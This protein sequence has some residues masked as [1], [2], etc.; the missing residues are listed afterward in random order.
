MH[1]LSIGTDRRVFEEGN[2][3]RERQASYAKTLGSLDVLIFSLGKRPEEC[4][5][6]LRLVPTNSSSR[7]LYGLDAYR[8]AKQLERPDVVTAQD[9]FE[10]GLI[11]LL[12]AR[13]FGVPLHVQVHTDF[14]SRQFARHS[15]LNR[16]RKMLASFVLSRAARIRVILERTKDELRA[17]GVSAPITVLPIFVDTARFSSL[18]RV[19]HPRFKIALLSIGRLEPEKRVELAVRALKESRDVGH[20]AGLTIVGSGSQEASLRS[21]AHSLGLEQYVEFVGWR[22]D[23]APY[24]ASADALLVPSVYE[25]YGIVTIEALAAGVPVIAT[26]V[27][28]A[29]EAGAIVAREGAFADTVIDWIAHGPRQGALHEYPYTSFEDYVERYCTDIVACKEV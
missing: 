20:D 21:L 23:I 26:D 18:Q 29:R 1:V 19:K 5:G 7:L 12:I 3:S 24:L 22:D 28:A 25:G 17:R 2:A 6:E 27:G 15:L 9:P 4:V 8:I 10:T 13:H 14:L 11:G 16:F